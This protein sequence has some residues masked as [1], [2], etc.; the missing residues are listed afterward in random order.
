MKWPK[1]ANNI[2]VRKQRGVESLMN[3]LPG[4]KWVLQ[5]VTTGDAEAYGR[6]E[7]IVMT[8]MKY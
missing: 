5:S 1:N 4:G 2:D 3:K 8:M 6:Y 7:D